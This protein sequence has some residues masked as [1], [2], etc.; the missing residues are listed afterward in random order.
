MPRRDG[1]RLPTFPTRLAVSLRGALWSRRGAGADE[2]PETWHYGVVERWWAEFNIAEHASRQGCA[3]A[4][5]AQAMH[6]S[7]THR[8]HIERS[9]SATR[10]ASAVIA[11][12]TGSRFVG[13]SINSS[14]TERSIFSQQ[15]PYDAQDPAGWAR[16]LLL[17]LDDAGLA[18]SPIEGRYTGIAPRRTTRRSSSPPAAR[19]SP[20]GLVEAA[21]PRGRAGVTF[22]PS[23]RPTVSAVGE[24]VVAIVRHPRAFFE[25]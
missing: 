3:P 7:L 4:L 12:M 24:D 22:R 14:R 18:I 19:R 10:L 21:G 17:M 13:S 16:W 20:L 5:Y 1:R 9:S 2:G 11:T 6:T 8:G 15:L 23:R 25:A